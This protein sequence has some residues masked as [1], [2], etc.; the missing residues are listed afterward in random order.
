MENMATRRF[1]MKK[2]FWM[3]LL[4]LAVTPVF[5][6]EQPALADLPSGEW[7]EIALGEEYKCLYDTPYS[8]F[9]RPASQ[10]TDELMVYFEGGGACWDAFTCGAVGQF[11]SQYEVNDAES[12]PMSQGL[13]DFGNEE[14]P[15]K[16]YNTVFVPYCSGDV[17]SGS[18]T[19]TFTLPTELA[20]ADKT[21]I[22]VEFNGFNNA[23]GVLEWV[24]G[25]Y[26]EPEQVFVT[27]CS[28]GGYGAIFHSANIMNNYTDTRVVM[29]ADASSGVTPKAWEGLVTWN[30]FD[31]MPEFIESLATVTREKYSTAYHIQQ[32]AKTFPNNTFAEYN[33]FLDQVQVGFYAFQTGRVVDASNFA[34]IAPEWSKGLIENT[35]RLDVTSP[36]YHW[37]MAGGTVHCITPLPEAYTYSVQGVRFVDWVGSLLDGSVSKNPQCDISAGKCLAAP[38]TE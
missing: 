21:E 22:T 12:L 13:L 1:F 24:Y 30:T 14:N 25:N 10:P 38:A 37:Y 7:S 29:L 27:G 16:D 18:S 17:H 11:A 19:Q 34:Q 6:Q 33:T 28:A 32:M 15:V 23:S 36:N 9:V 26:T 8:F 31:G 2:L 35:A 20:T 4:C 5:A 3:V